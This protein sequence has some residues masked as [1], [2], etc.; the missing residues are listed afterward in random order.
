MER[1]KIL[2][3]EDEDPKRRH[4]AE[5]LRSRGGSWELKQAKSVN[6]AIEAIEKELPDLLLLDMSLP[7]FDVGDD[8][9]GG[10]PQGFGGVEVVRTMM[11]SEVRCPTIVIT[12]YEAFPAETGEQVE[13]AVLVA[14]LEAY[15][16]EQYLGVLH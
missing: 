3:V 7:T 16:G 10:R 8:E 2:L 1:P 11:M 13:L 6:S 14:E 5:F 12:G 15:L 4:I 9:P